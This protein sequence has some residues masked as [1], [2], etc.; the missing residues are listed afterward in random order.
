LNILVIDTSTEFAVMALKAGSKYFLSV[1]NLGRKHSSLLFA[2]LDEL[3][4]KAGLTVQDIDLFC[5]GIGPGSFTGV[6]VAVSTVRA[7]SQILEK[8]ALGIKSHDIY[9]GESTLCSDYTIVAFDAKKNRVFGALYK[10]RKDNGLDEIIAPGDFTIAEV[11]D[12]MPDMST[13]TFIGDGYNRYKDTIEDIAGKKSLILSVRSTP[14][15]DAE[16]ICILAEKKYSDSPEKF[17]KPDNL[18]PF[19]A[20]KSDAEVARDI[21][22]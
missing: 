11:M 17:A 7:L 15:P 10:N 1:E 6:R 22:L 5:A 2:K 19:Y 18:K 14:S 16:K 4:L 3:L 20:R 21:N 13:A 9:A 8:P 12:N